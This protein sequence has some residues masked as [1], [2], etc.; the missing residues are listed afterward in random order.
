MSKHAKKK[1]S[2]LLYEFL[3]RTISTALVD[4]D[5]KKSSMAM[6]LITKHFKPG[7][8]L[9]KEFRLI[10]SLVRTTVSSPNVAANILTEAKSASIKHDASRLELE[11]ISLV[12]AII[13]SLRDTEFFEQQIDEYK[14]YATAQVLLNEW[15]KLPKGQA[16]LSTVASYEDQLMR[17][18]TTE[19]KE[20]PTVLINDE[21]PGTNRALMRIMMKK[22]HEKYDCVLTH[23]QSSLLRSYALAG[24]KTDPGI[25]FSKLVDIRNTTLSKIDEYAATYR[26]E[27]AQFVLKKLNETREM[28]INESLDKVDDETV[29]RFMLYA[30]LNEELTSE[31]E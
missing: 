20:K 25:V 23:E 9:Y 12:K 31:D 16:D 15:R 14:A 3:I 8:E 5:T 27:N 28:L 6:K 2:G 30:K 1:N 18:L 19:K 10:N 17:W 13:G 29:S 7:T 11:K 21:S 26:D 24:V 22:L 4:G